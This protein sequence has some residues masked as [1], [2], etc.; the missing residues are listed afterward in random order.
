MI[1]K[2]LK[3]NEILKL[4]RE[5]EGFVSAYDWEWRKRNGKY[6]FPVTTHQRALFHFPAKGKKAKTDNFITLFKFEDIVKSI[7][8]INTTHWY[9]FKGTSISHNKARFDQEVMLDR[10]DCVIVPHKKGLEFINLSDPE[11]YRPLNLDLYFM[12]FRDYGYGELRLYKDPAGRFWIGK[13]EKN[14]YS[15]FEKL[16]YWDH[17]RKSTYGAVSLFKYSDIDNLTF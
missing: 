8:P 4:N 2:N 14:I 17:G 12:E 13:M 16:R 11:T 6:W 7:T 10:L 15:T 1:Y 3:T 5:P 9:R